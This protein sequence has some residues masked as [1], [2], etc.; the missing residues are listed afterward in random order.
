MYLAEIHPVFAF[1]YVWACLICLKSGSLSIIAII[2]A[3]YFGSVILPELDVT[4]NIDED[5]RIK[6]LAI[7]ALIGATSINI[8]GIN[9]VAKVQKIFLFTKVG[10]IILIC[11]IGL[12]SI[13][14]GDTREIAMDNFT[15]IFSSPLPSYGIMD[16]FLYITNIGSAVI[17]AL[18][19]YDGFDTLNMLTEEVIE[20]QKNLPIS[21]IFG[22]ALVAVCYLFVN[23]AYF[24]I[25]PANVLMYS[26]A[27][28]ISAAYNVWGYWAAV[29]IA[30]LVSFSALGTLITSILSGSR[31]FYAAAKDN[32]VPFSYYV[33]QISTDFNTPY[34]AIIIETIVAL[35]M[36][37]PG[38]FDSL[39]NY[40]GFTAW[41][42]YGLCAVALIVLRR[43]NIVQE[44][45]FKVR[46]YPIVPVV[47]I[48]SALGVVIS[49]FITY[50]IPTILASLFLLAAVPVY[51]LFYWKGNMITKLYR[52]MKNKENNNMIN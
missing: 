42:F 49:S 15:N 23:I 31:I 29:V 44:G 5:Y 51:Y 36:L 52:N 50:P 13:T 45:T 39:V 25:L 47:F 14:F 38:N 40:F 10:S 28:A 41:I 33:G 35:V 20:P 27:V 24:L 43:R 19:A 7:A 46:P 9:W 2:F 21:I 17:V 22:M 6:L 48:I 26:Q 16:I 37:I 12:Y 18:W 32:L 30:I 8:V 3:R 4:S 11:I 34:V 1:C